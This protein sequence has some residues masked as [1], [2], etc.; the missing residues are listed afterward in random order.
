M[1]EHDRQIV[2]LYN[3]CLSKSMEMEI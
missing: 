1:C 2:L 3:L